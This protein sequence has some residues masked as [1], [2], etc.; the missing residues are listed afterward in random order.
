MRDPT[1]LREFYSILQETH[2]KYCPDQRPGQ[3]FSNWLGWVMNVK[4]R[5]IFFPEADEML[6]LLD[7][8]I[9]TH[10]KYNYGY[11]LFEED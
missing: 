9:Q 7:E 8:Y 10:C 3:F 5:D 2:I 11:G 4:K 1:K 6:K